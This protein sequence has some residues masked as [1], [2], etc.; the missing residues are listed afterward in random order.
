MLQVLLVLALRPA[1]AVVVVLLL[2]VNPHRGL[3]V[4]MLTRP[5]ANASGLLSPLLVQAEEAAFQCLWCD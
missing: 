1:A 4:G 2:H 5:A 3:V